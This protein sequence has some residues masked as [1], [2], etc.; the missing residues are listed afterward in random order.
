MT[1]KS[2]PITPHCITESLQIPQVEDHKDLKKLSEENLKKI[3][4]K[5]GIDSGFIV[6]ESFSEYSSDDESS[7]YEEF[8]GPLE[9]N[10]G[11]ELQERFQD[12][13]K[14]EETL[15]L[16]RQRNL[17][18]TQLQHL[19]KNANILVIGPDNAGKT[20]LINSL[21]YMIK[22]KDGETAWRA[23]ASYD[24]GKKYKFKSVPIWPEHRG[25]KTPRVTFYEAGGFSQIKEVEKAA[26][27]LQYTMEGRFQEGRITGLLQLFL[28][29]NIQDITERYR[30]D[31]EDPRVLANRKIDA[32]IHVTPANQKP[33]MAL[34]K[35]IRMAVNKSKD[36]CIKKIPILTC[37]TSPHDY[38]T[39]ET[40]C[41][42]ICPLADYDLGAFVRKSQEGH[43]RR[44]RSKQNLEANRSATVLDPASVRE[45]LYYRPAFDP[46]SDETDSSNIKPDQTIDQSL[47]TLFEESLRLAT[48]EQP[49]PFHKKI[50]QNLVGYLRT[51]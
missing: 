42:P 21:A 14:R 6:D 4:S 28:L 49:R 36:P 1:P 7:Q 34:F 5:T 26:T 50:C 27:L 24:L 20:S 11:P 44:N 18:H 41:E 12:L 30:E 22:K 29:M 40:D 37:V 10:L 32:I 38:S 45:I 47:L 39:E 9:E 13:K 31:P 19:K 46:L 8:D 15:K 35:L 16:D 33:D 48:R 3:S 23:A 25:H 43:I 51:R 2:T 17:L